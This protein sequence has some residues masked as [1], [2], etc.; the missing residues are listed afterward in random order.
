MTVLFLENLWLLAFVLV[1]AELVLI[2]VWYWRR[3]ALWVRLAWSEPILGL[4]LLI[5]S[6]GVVT[7]REAVAK[8]CGDLVSWVEAEDIASIASVL[9]PIFE[10]EG[11]DREE[12]AAWVGRGLA[13]FDFAQARIG[14]LEIRFPNKDRCLCSFRV[15]CRV[16]LAAS[17]ST[18]IRTSWNITWTKSGD[19]WRLVG[20]TPVPIAPLQLQSLHQVFR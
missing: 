10:A 2:C 7:E 5:V 11:M 9:A 6:W 16:E 20:V 8:C 13:K 1:A 12:F 4:L 3:T 15:G 17:G 14:G 19:R 18:W